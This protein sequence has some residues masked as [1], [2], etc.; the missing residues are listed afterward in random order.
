MADPKIPVEPDP[1]K[2]EHLVEEK[3]FDY[4]EKTLPEDPSDRA[5]QKTRDNVNPAIPSV[6][7]GVP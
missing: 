5:G 4:I 3:P 7:R 1:A 6:K 2:R